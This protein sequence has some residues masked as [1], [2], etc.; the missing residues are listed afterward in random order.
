MSASP[1]AAG[2]PD[3]DPVSAGEPAPPAERP[4]GSRPPRRLRALLV[5]LAIAAVLAVIL[6]VGIGTGNNGG[7]GTTNNSSGPQVGSRAPTFSLPRLGGGAP[8]DLDALG[9]DRHRPVVLNFFSSTCP[10]CVAETPLL[11]STARAEERR[12]ADVQF[13]GVDVLDTPA[14][15]LV[16]ARQ[17]GL[18]YP[19][20]EDPTLAVASVHYG[21]VGPPLT[22]FVA[23]SGRV[24]A[25]HLGTLSVADLRRGL[26]LLTPAA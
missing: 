24:V 10:P 22:V 25:R 21:M 20:G 11:A 12:H 2:Q 23:A 18:T 17:A 3:P 19:I 6:F 1:S 15:G 5:G 7:N 4:A 13:V 26:A 16:F 14:A 9:V 8:V